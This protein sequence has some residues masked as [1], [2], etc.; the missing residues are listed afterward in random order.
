MQHSVSIQTSIVAGL[1]AM[2]LHRH[3]SP[4]VSQLLQVHFHQRQARVCGPKIRQHRPPGVHGQRMPIG[5]AFRV[6]RTHLGRCQHVTLGLHRSCS[7][8]HLEQEKIY[9]LYKYIYKVGITHWDHPLLQVCCDPA[10]TADLIY[11]IQVL[12][13]RSFTFY[14]QK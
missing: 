5:G 11:P 13:L 8:Q 3:I 1:P 10:Y 6:V 7:Q 2:L 12:S 14:F 9:K 4:R